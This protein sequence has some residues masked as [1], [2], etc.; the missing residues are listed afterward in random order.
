MIS[1]KKTKLITYTAIITLVVLNS[2]LAYKFK[3]NSNEFGKVY[4]SLNK[5]L[6]QKKTELATAEQNFVKEKENENLVL[7]GNL[8]LIDIEGK[9]VLAKDIFKNNSL[10]FRYSELNCHECIDAEINALVKN[11]EKIKNIVF[12][13][14][15]QNTR[16]LF[17]F[18]EN[19]SNMGLTN[20]KM[21]YAKNENLLIP[22][23]KLN[24]PYYF[25]VNANL[26]MTN[27]FI[28]QKE[29]PKLSDTYLNYTT[30]NF[31]NK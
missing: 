10:V 16:D 22:I 12:I 6:S 9:T 30:K 7:D 20:I 21:Y 31:L 24:A 18:H 15:Y 11:K 8:P 17:V 26:V 4:Q 19:F 28:P 2:V 23:E 13:A 1:E 5:E 14:Y 3:S 29:K 27:F 25:C